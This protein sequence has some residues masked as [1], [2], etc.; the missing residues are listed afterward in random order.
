M[1]GQVP[2]ADVSSAA[3]AFGLSQRAFAA[4][5]WFATISRDTR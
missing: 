4:S 3:G 2:A 5:P 1:K